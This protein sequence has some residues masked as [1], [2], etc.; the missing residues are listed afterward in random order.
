M[1][2][3][4]TVWYYLVASVD[5]Q[6]DDTNLL[7]NYNDNIYSFEQIHMEHHQIAM[8][9]EKYVLRYITESFLISHLNK[10][11]VKYM[12]IERIRISRWLNFCICEMNESWCCCCILQLQ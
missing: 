1:S 10:T 4:W 9:D 12:T 11:C 5:S 3:I 6:E 7:M 8:K 2:I